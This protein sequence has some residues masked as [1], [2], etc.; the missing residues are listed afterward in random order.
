VTEA[1]GQIIAPSFVAGV[2]VVN[3]VVTEAAPILR[4]RR[5]DMIG[6]T[7]EQVR[8]YCAQR[9]WQFYR[10]HPAPAADGGR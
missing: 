6:W 1:L 4:H 7:V 9:G 2:V 3:R 8:A 10:V 5:L